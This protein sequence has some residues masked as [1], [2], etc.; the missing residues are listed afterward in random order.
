MLKMSSTSLHLLSIF[1]KL[2]TALLI[3]SAGNCPIIF[4]SE[5]HISET[6]LGFR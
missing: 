2:V 6:V 1:L 3:E 4:S 5:T